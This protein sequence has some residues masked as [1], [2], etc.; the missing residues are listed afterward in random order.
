MCL[1]L[2]QKYLIL[3]FCSSCSFHSSNTDTKKR[4]LG[5]PSLMEPKVAKEIAQAHWR[6][7][8]SV[9]IPLILYAWVSTLQMSC[10]L[11]LISSTYSFQIIM[12][13]AY[14][15]GC[16]VEGLLWTRDRPVAATSAWEHTAFTKSKHSY[17]R[18][19]SNPQSQQPNGRLTT[20]STARSPESASSDICS[21]SISEFS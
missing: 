13:S 3:L 2:T 15:Q 9:K 1:Y 16:T 18:W 7:C 12:A 11:S 19:D 21:I 17:S 14:T 4:Q 8:R 6:V 20:P 5:R 10:F